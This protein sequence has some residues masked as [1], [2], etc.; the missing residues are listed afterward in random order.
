MH[1]TSESLIQNQLLDLFLFLG[2]EWILQLLLILSVI[3][4]AITFERMYHF[5]KHCRA[6]EDLPKQIDNHLAAKK[7]DDA[8]K[9]LQDDSSHVATVAIEG[10][11]SIG[12]GRAAVEELMAA[13]TKQAKGR[14][15]RGLAFLGTLGN[16]A[17]FI[18]LF[19]TVLGIIRAFRD[20]SENTME[21]SS[22]VMAG[23]AEALVATAVGLL[24]ALPAVA[25]FN[26]FQRYIKSQIAQSD[27]VSHI[28]LAYLK[29]TDR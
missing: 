29:S 24:V 7:V 21:G 20:L 6:A 13:A 8:K 3:S 10:I 27:A 2:S 28:V 5:W 12:R 14:M 16:N 22:A 4:L 23:I 15:E 17:P 18:G 11:N 26:L 19:G 1:E 25:I 9:L